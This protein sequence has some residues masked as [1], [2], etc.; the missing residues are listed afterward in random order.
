MSVKA[1]TNDDRIAQML[2]RWR[3]DLADLLAAEY[4]RGAQDTLM[5]IHEFTSAQLRGQA[6]PPAPD[7]EEAEIETPEGRKRAP[8]GLVGV[9]VK[10]ALTEAAPNGLPTSEFKNRARDETERM[11]SMGSIRNELRRGAIAGR[12]REEG[13]RWFLT[14][15]P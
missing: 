2:D 11:V 8:K 15:A 3:D 5:R 4:A 6:P 9:L 12:Y 14:F 10:R 1:M 7:D 13:G